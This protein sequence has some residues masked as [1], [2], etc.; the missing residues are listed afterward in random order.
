VSFSFFT[1]LLA[2]LCSIKFIKCYSLSKVC[3][4]MF[5]SIWS[6]SG[7]KI[8]GQ[9]NWCLLLLLM[10]LIHKSPWCAYVSVTCVHSIRIHVCK[11][12]YV[13]YN[14][15]FVYLLTL[16]IWYLYLVSTSAFLLKPRPRRTIYIRILIY[17]RK[18]TDLQYI[19][20]KLG[21]LAF[22]PLCM[23]KLHEGQCIKGHLTFMHVA[24]ISK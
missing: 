23:Q 19:C 18:R 2:A 8:I 5:R 24:V 22:M 10:L 6:S 15:L 20:I 12:Y 17:F 7:V 3:H 1:V 4:Y 21:I 14:Y 9:G 16:Y 11:V 13:P